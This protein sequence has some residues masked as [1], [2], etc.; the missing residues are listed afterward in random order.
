MSERY[1][2]DS[3]E[4]EQHENRVESGE[5]QNGTSKAEELLKTENSKKIFLKKNTFI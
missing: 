3:I 2:I 4:E 5:D 1:K